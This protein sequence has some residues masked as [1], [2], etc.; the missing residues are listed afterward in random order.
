MKKVN[1]CII[2]GINKAEVTDR[3]RM[4]RPIK[5]V[6]KSCHSAR[7]IDDFEYIMRLRNNRLKEKTM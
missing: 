5:R 3:K 4:G 1:L 7:L 2:C 6:C